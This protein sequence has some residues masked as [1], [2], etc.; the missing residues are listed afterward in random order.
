MP[1]DSNI[2]QNVEPSEFAIIDR[3]RKIL[4]REENWDRNCDQ[5]FDPNAK[6]TKFSLFDALNKASRDATGKYDHRCAA[7]QEVRFLIDEIKGVDAYQPPPGCGPRHRLKGF[8]NDPTTTL[9]DIWE[10]LSEAKTRLAEKQQQQ[11]Q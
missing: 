10:L 6:A 11:Q 5:Y 3:A 9:N 1:N 7:N 2:H 8:N 4:D